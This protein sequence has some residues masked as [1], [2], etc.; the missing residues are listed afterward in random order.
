MQDTQ[1][2]AG[3]AFLAGRLCD[4]WILRLPLLWWRVLNGVQIVIRCL[5][6][7]NVFCRLLL[8]RWCSRATR[9][10]QMGTQ[11]NTHDVTIW[12]LANF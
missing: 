10:W 1:M 11:S 4:L 6:C 12:G 9:S 2:V 5:S 3:G 8:W 7:E